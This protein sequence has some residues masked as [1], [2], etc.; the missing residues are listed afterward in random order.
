MWG[1]DI[2]GKAY[3]GFKPDKLN[4][5]GYFELYSEL[6]KIKKFPPLPTYVPIPEHQ[7][8]GG[9]DLIFNH[10]QGRGPDSLAARPTASG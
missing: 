7:K 9:N 5:S 1:Q 2:G 3:K 6:L 4:K 10:L 8:M